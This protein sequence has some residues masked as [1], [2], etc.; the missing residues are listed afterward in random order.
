LFGLLAP[1]V[2]IDETHAFLAI[3]GQKGDAVGEA[4]LLQLKL[5]LLLVLHTSDGIQSRVYSPHCGTT[6]LSQQEQQSLR[7]TFLEDE[8]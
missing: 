1:K 5:T 2:L 3:V 7:V 6:S 8:L 4:Q